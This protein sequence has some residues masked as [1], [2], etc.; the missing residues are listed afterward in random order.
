VSDTL[1]R[2]L[3]R[4]GRPRF[5]VLQERGEP[6]G[7]EMEIAR[8]RRY[9]GALTI[10]D[11]HVESSVFHLREHATKADRVIVGPGSRSDSMVAVLSGPT[12]YHFID[13]WIEKLP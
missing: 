12:V 7:A 3:P 2:R 4:P 8:T 5:V 10:R 1:G 11:A 6:S 9:N 13:T